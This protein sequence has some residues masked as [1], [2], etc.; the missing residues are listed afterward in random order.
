[1]ERVYQQNLANLENLGDEHFGGIK[2]PKFSLVFK[3]EREGEREREREMFLK[4]KAH[5]A[6]KTGSLKGLLQRRPR[7]GEQSEKSEKAAVC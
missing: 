5:R 4:D 2:I 6:L 7:F 1:M 3:K